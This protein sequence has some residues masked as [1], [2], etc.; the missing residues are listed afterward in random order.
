MRILDSAIGFSPPLPTQPTGLRFPDTSD[1]SLCLLSPLP[2]SSGPSGPFGPLYLTRYA[3][4]QY[5][6][7][8]LNTLFLIFLSSPLRIIPHPLP[9]DLTLKSRDFGPSDHFPPWRLHSKPSPLTF[10]ICDHQPCLLDSHFLALAAS[11]LPQSFLP[12]V[13]PVGLS[14]VGRQALWALLSPNL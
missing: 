3:A 2:I 12:S 13:L 1:C 10:S 5:S 8:F 14:L 11:P 6:S 7:L 4:I 9:L